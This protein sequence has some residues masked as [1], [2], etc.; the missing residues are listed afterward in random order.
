MWVHEGWWVSG[1]DGWGST[2]SEAQVREDGM[3]NSERG[4]ENGS[5]IWSVNK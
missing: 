3:K 1:L 4:T 5:N 2:L